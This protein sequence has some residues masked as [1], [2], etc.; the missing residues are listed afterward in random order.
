MP[1]NGPVNE[2]CKCR[3]GMQ[4]VKRTY[5]HRDGARVVGSACEGVVLLKAGHFRLESEQVEVFQ[6]SEGGGSAWVCRSRRVPRRAKQ[7]YWLCLGRLTGTIVEGDGVNCRIVDD[8]ERV[9]KAG[10]WVGARSVGIM[11]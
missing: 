2:K 1:D 8:G 3:V 5:G 6:H 11:S 7:L 4:A 9:C 10:V